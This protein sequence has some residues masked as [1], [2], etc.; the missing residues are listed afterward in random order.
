MFYN[1]CHNNLIILV[2]NRK[3]SNSHEAFS[4]N[5]TWEEPYSN[6]SRSL[7][8]TFLVT[9]K[10]LKDNWQLVSNKQGKKRNKQ[11]KKGQE[12]KREP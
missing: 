5:F 2:K 12:K 3:K 11:G 8:T 6:G 4:T 9:R 1:N 10:I 7:W